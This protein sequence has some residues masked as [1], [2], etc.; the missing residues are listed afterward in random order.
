METEILD[1]MK[2]Y[3]GPLPGSG[4]VLTYIF[5]VLKGYVIDDSSLC[6]HRVVEAFK[7]AYAKRTN[8]G[9]PDFVDDI[10]AV[11]QI[12]IDSMNSVKIKLFPANSSLLI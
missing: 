3:A 1:E 6:W 12:F 10:E 11:R 9:D 2:L 7:F 5:D 4:I 8:L